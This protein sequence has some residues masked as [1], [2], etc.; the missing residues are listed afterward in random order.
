MLDYCSIDKR[1]LAMGRLWRSVMSMS[2]KVCGSFPQ[3]WYFA[4]SLHKFLGQTNNKF[5]ACDHRHL[6]DGGEGDSRELTEPQSYFTP[7]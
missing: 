1:D 4:E 3:M 7:W 6:S 2:K 5:L